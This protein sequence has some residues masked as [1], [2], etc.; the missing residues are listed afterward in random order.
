MN[1]VAHNSPKGVPEWNLDATKQRPCP[2]LDCSRGRGSAAVVTQH[3]QHSGRRPEHC[4]CCPRIAAD[5]CDTRF[6]QTILGSAPR[7]APR[8]AA[9]W[10]I[11]GLA[12][13]IINSQLLGRFLLCR[14]SDTPRGNGDTVTREGAQEWL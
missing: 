3:P 8:R 4:H 10:W 12:P 14:G 1:Q 11:L 5:A 9:R 6:P 2:I 13:E 7:P